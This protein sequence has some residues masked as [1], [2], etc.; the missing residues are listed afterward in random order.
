MKKFPA[1]TRGVYLPGV[2]MTLTQA[3]IADRQA[4]RAKEKLDPLTPGQ[5]VVE[6]TKP[7]HPSKEWA[8]KKTHLARAH[9]LM[10]GGQ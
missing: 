6:F 10:Q 5:I 8:P 4:E 2:G 7:Q 1:S 9:R 3:N